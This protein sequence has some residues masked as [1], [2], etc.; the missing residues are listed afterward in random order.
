LKDEFQ[1]KNSIKIKDIKDD[2]SQ[3]RLTHQ[4][5]D[6]SHE[7]MITSKNHIKTNNEVSFSINKI[8][9]NENEKHINKK[10]K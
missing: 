6:Q 2:Q 5:C 8:L 7:I 9:M 4:T 3:F 1:E 10:Q